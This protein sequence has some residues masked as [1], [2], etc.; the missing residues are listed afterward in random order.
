VKQRSGLGRGLS[1]LI[2]AESYQPVKG[3][4]QDIPLSSIRANRMQ[5]RQYFDEAALIELADSM[6]QLGLL[7]PILVRPVEGGEFELIAGERR[8]RAARRLGWQTITAIVQDAGDKD[9]LERAIVENVQRMDLNPIEEA[10]AYLELSQR[11]GLTHEAIAA[12]VGKSRTAVSNSMR[13]LQLPENIQR[14]VSEG[15]LSAGHARALLSVPDRTLQEEL[16]NKCVTEQLS[17]RSLEDIV[18]QFVEPDRAETELTDIKADNNSEKY[19][20][21]KSKPAGFIELEA[22]LSERLNTVV[23]VEKGEKKGKVI[24]EF[25]DIDDLE[26]IYRLMFR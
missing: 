7:Q 3:E 13:L 24:I 12:R 11:F 6:A 20:Q 14:M 21:Q 5:P 18:R 26:R 8:L 1:S 23:R 25:A 16:A 19:S 9:S 15:K 17:V 4:A 2:S 22:L 10:R